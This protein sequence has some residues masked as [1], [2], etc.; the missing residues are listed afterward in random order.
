[1]VEDHAR[2][3]DV[4][5]GLLALIAIVLSAPSSFSGDAPR[6]TFCVASSEAG[7]DVWIS[8][9]FAT[10]PDRERL[11]G[12]FKSVIERKGAARADAQCP[13]PREDKIEAV[14]AQFAA[15]Q[16]NLRLGAAVHQVFASDFPPQR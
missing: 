5:R 14:N 6:W 1:M 10:G 16:F 12:D 13:L 3:G 15:E 8:N 9:V 11:E 2:T 4:V 7:K